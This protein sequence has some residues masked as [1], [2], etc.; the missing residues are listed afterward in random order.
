MQSL[1]HAKNE[2]A[3]LEIYV[4]ILS[5][6]LFG[7]SMPT[8]QRFGRRQDAE[9]AFGDLEEGSEKRKRSQFRT[10]VEIESGWSFRFH[11]LHTEPHEWA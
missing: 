10:D 9:E 11:A 6:G 1:Y 2:D 5:G 3:A 8:T 4:F 7:N